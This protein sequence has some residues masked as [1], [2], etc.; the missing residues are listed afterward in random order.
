MS[1]VRYGAVLLVAATLTGCTGQLA[2]GGTET[3]NGISGMIAINPRDDRGTGLVAAVYSVNYRPDSGTGTAETTTVAYG[4]E[5]RFDPPAGNRYNIFIWDT[6]GSRGAFVSGLTADTALGVITLARTGVLKIDVPQSWSN[7]SEVSACR[8][9]IAGSPY[10]FMADAG[11]PVTVSLLPEGVYP[12]DLVV[13]LAGP[14]STPNDGPGVSELQMN[15][16]I[17]PAAADTLFLEIP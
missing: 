9:T 17:D 7:A 15:A 13:E 5:F 14:M 8:L 16:V 12:L 4:E 3:T 2:G 11:E 6:A 1:M 10:F